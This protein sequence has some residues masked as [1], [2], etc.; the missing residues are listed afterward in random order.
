[1][2]LVRYGQPGA[3]RPGIL[4]RDGAIRDLS[5]VIR[6]ID[7]S[8]L[9]P[10]RL[11]E[12]QGLKVETLPLVQGASS[13]RPTCRETGQVPLHRAQLCRPRCRDRCGHSS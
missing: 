2:K 10:P 5:G 12:L 7:G 1:M 8:A 6:D 13:P 9:T 3:E 11:R 4:D